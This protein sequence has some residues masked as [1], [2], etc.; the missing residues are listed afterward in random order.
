MQFKVKR[1]CK[2]H[3]RASVEQSLLSS[4]IRGDS[5]R[6]EPIFASTQLEEAKAQASL[7]KKSFHADA[8]FHK[9]ETGL[10]RSLT[11]K[12]TRR[13]TLTEDGEPELS[14][15]AQRLRRTLSTN[16]REN[17]A[18][19]LIQDYGDEPLPVLNDA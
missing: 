16:Y 5:S 11:R 13:R 17:T 6:I 4:P 14:T 2:G 18:R 19:D 8:S 10:R 9:S 12:S 1:H 15:A 3:S 7:K